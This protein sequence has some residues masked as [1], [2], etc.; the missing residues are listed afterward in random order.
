MPSVLI[1]GAS[2]GIGHELARQYVADG[3][4]VLATARKKDDCEAL[5][6]LGAHPYLL[7]VTSADSI[8]G[9]GWNLDGE[10]L[11]A[12]FFVAGVYGPRHDGFPVQADFDN[13]MAINVKGPY[14]FARA[15][16][17]TMIRARAGHILNIGSFA[18][19]RVIEA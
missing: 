5:R 7:D 3:W 14:L 19:E 15:C 13:V 16:L 1:I 10:E 18:S 6:R 8:A 9:L 17:R 2:R 11:D 12:A 4:R